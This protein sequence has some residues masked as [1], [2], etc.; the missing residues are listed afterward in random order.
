MGVL[1]HVAA[2]TVHTARKGW[3]N[4]ITSEEKVGRVN[5]HKVRLQEHEYSPAFCFPRRGEILLCRTL[6]QRLLFCN[7]LTSEW[8]QTGKGVHQG[9]ICHPVYLTSMQNTSCKMPD[10]MKHK[11]ES[12]LPGEINNL[13]YADDTTLMAE[14]EEELKSLLMKV[15]EGE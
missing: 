8:F 1:Y 13:R 10:R 12:R 9:C 5:C 6:Q 7:V 4:F 3:S 11:L 15:K 14:S 2:C